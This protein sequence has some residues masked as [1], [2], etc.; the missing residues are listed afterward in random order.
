MIVQERD[1]SS[2]PIVNLKGHHIVSSFMEL[3]HLNDFHTS[4]HDFANVTHAPL[5]SFDGR[6]VLLDPKW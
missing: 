5:L 3:F 1:R 4:I 2:V 6:D